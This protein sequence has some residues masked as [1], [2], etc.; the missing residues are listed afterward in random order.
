MTLEMVS[1]IMQK[2]SG[3]ALEQQWNGTGMEWGMAMGMMTM[4]RDSVM[5]ADNSVT[6]WDREWYHVTF[7]LL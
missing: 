5:Q 1:E 3:M 4:R 7:Q 2:W 6:H